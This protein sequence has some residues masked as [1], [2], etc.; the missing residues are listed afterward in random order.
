MLIK[1]P[2]LHGAGVLVVNRLDAFSWG[3]Q[4]CTGEPPHEVEAGRRKLSA[5]SERREPEKGRSDGA[6]C[7]PAGFSEEAAVKLCMKDEK[8]LAG[9]AAEKRGP[10]KEEGRP[11][12]RALC[13]RQ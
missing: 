10:G 3:S 2:S 1:C 12:T 6:R 8:D 5:G 9:R 11:R 13:P 4:E 7:D